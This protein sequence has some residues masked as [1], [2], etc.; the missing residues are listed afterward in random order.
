MDPRIRIHT[1][2]SW[3]RNTGF[4]SEQGPH[5]SSL[6]GGSS[7]WPNAPVDAC[8]LGRRGLFLA[9]CWSCGMPGSSGTLSSP[10][11]P[12]SPASTPSSSRRMFVSRSATW[13]MAIVTQAKRGRR[14][15]SISLS[16]HHKSLKAFML[17]SNTRRYALVLHLF[18]NISNV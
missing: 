7:T 17:F 8:R 2:M 11:S 13:G 12:S 15:L 1:K 18:N 16:F 5:L 6:S 4:N 3:I 10:S 14:K 9:R